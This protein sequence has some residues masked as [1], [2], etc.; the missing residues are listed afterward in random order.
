MVR[1]VSRTEGLVER[2]RAQSA[3]HTGLGEDRA[4]YVLATRGLVVKHVVAIELRVVV[5]AVVAVAADAVLVWLTHKPR[6]PSGYSTDSTASAQS[7][8]KKQPEGGEHAGEKGRGG[9]EKRKKFRVAVWH[10]KQEMPV[11]RARVSRTGGI[12]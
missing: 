3:E 2:R 12:K 7:R 5:A 6:C 8:A 1:E 4:W 9:A 11:A 10:R